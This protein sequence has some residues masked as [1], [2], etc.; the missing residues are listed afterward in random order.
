MKNAT[1]LLLCILG[2]VVLVASG[3][4]CEEAHTSG[5]LDVRSYGAVGNGKTDDT[6]AF[7]KAMKAALSSHRRLFIPSGIYRVQL[8][9]P[10]G[11]TMTGAGMSTSWLKGHLDFGSSSTISDLKI[12]DAGN[13]AVYNRAGATHTSFV[14][15]QLRGGGSLASGSA[16]PVVSLGFDK[17]CSAIRFQDCAIERNLGSET[18]SNYDNGF[19]DITVYSEG[20]TVPADISFVGCHVGVSNGQG[21]HDSGSPRMGIECYSEDG[22]AGWQRITLSGC[23]F[24][25]ADAHTIDF[26]DT[27]DQRSSGVLVEGCLIKGGGYKHLHWGYGID[28][29][30]PLGAVIRGN[31]I[32]RSWG[33]TL[34]ITDRGEAGYNGPATQISGN[35]FDLAR[36]NGIDPGSDVPIGLH[37]DGNRFTDNT[38]TLNYSSACIDLDGCHDNTVSGNVAHLGGRTFAYQFG[39]SSGNTITANTVD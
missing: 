22:S 28:L 32:W 21:G 11:V 8:T 10:D 12:G 30:M 14:R 13:S 37:G 9:V 38:I 5:D 24:E 36:D 3:Q 23:T 35:T 33:Q 2:A 15:C 26:S 6:E 27:A 7:V 1:L 19:N 20:A 34:F 39:G 4:A 25:A 18:T 31:T 29:E 16:G 17:S